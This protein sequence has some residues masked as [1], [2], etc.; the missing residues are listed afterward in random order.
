MADVADQL[1]GGFPADF[2]DCRG[3]VV[4]PHTTEADLD[5]LVVRQATVDLADHALA[6]AG[7]ADHDHGFELVR[8]GAQMTFLFGSQRHMNQEVPQKKN[9]R[10]SAGKGFGVAASPLNRVK[11]ELGIILL[12][13]LLLW[14][15]VDSI[16]ADFAN[17]LLIL[18]FFGGTSAL[19]L[20][21]RTRRTLQ[22]LTKTHEAQQK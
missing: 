11:L 1:T 10:P 21:L 17:Q 4:A 5:Q 7:I 8:E 19:W 20:V 13:G 18:A 2:L 12:V 15:A 22:Q 3:A 14:L 9:E 6:E 16:T